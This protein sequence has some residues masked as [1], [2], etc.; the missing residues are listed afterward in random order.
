MAVIPTGKLKAQK[1]RVKT[2]C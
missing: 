1:T 2:S